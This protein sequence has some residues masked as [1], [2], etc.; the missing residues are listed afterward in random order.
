MSKN[1]TNAALLALFFGSVGAHWFY[2]GKRQMGILY[3]VFFWT[4]IPAIL[5]LISAISWLEMDDL[6]FN[7]RYLIDDDYYISKSAA[8]KTNR[9]VLPQ[10]S[11]HGVKSP[12]SLKKDRKKIS[13][14]I[15]EGKKL[16]IEYDLPGAIEN[17]QKAL[18]LDEKN[19]AIHFN[20]AC[21]Y[22]LSEKTERSLYHLEQ[23]VG[24][25]FDDFDKIKTHDALAYLRI[26]P[27]FNTFE[28]K[29]LNITTQKQVDPENSNLLDSTPNL[30][31]QLK[32]LQS[33][34]KSGRISEEDFQNE[35]R[36]LL[37]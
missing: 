20:L 24:N 34:R 8:P 15:Q 17:F 1:R 29:N 9:P 12:L 32:K 10:Y 28:S 3:A 35:K 36:K 25:G 30:L 26:Q 21:A 16:F 31:E 14:L 11:D 23:A 19:A 6:T 4:G 33:M 37:S 27:E 18:Q 13:A 5:G 7:Q 22:S 2:L